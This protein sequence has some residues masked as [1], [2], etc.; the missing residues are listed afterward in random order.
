[1][2]LETFPFFLSKKAFLLGTA[3]TTHQNNFRP[4]LLEIDAKP[5]RVRS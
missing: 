2:S 4:T 3:L 5:Q 1:M